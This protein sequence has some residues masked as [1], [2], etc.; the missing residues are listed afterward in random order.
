VLSVASFP[1]GI[2]LGIRG[3]AVAYR[4]TIGIAIDVAIPTEAG[5]DYA[6]GRARSPTVIRWVYDLALTVSF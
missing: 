4:N 1:K 3:E 2:D 5:F 6:A